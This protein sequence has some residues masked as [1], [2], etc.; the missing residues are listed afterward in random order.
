MDLYLL[1]LDRTVFKTD[2]HFADFCEVLKEKFGID[3]SVLREHEHRLQQNP[4]PYSPLDDIRYSDEIDLDPE[5]VKSLATENLLAK[6]KDYVY[7]DAADFIRKLTQGGDRVVLV[8]VG[9]HEYQQHKVTLS[10]L[11]QNLPLI[12]TREAK[13]KLFAKILQ[14]GEQKTVLESESLKIE[15]DRIYFVDDRAGT[16]DGKLPTDNRF[17]PIRL[18]RQDA[19]YSNQPTPSGIREINSFNEIN[20]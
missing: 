15:A 4:S 13:S 12:V 7:P 6:G 8:T 11:L 3:P 10:S 1:D 14:F 9:T 16:F 17:M 18:V 19:A 2:E 5:E 20:V